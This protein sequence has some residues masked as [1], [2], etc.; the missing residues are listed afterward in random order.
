[1]ADKKLKISLELDDKIF[2]AGVKRA[3]DQLAQLSKSPQIMQMQTQLNQRLSSMGYGGLPGSPDYEKTQQARRKSETEQKRYVEDLLKTQEKL[4]KNEEKLFRLKQ[5]GKNVDKDMADLSA[6]KLKNEGMLTAATEKRVRTY[7][8]LLSNME[9]EYKMGGVAGVKEAWRGMGGAEKA[10][11]AATTA[12]G[13]I[14]LIARTVQYMARRPIEIAA[15][16]GSAVSGLTGLQ[17]SQARTGEY[18]YEGMFGNDRNKATAAAGKAKGMGEIADWGKLIAGA[19]IAGGALLAIPTGGLSLGGAAAIAG[20]IGLA[21]SSHG[22]WDSQKYKAYQA[23]QYTQ[24]FTTV[25]QSEHE[26]Q[27][28][29]KAAIDRLKDTAGRDIGMQRALGLGDQGYYGGG[30]YLQG[31]M[32]LGFT[33]QM[34]TQ[35]SQGILGAGGSSAMARQSGTAL[36]AE[37]GLNLTNAPQLLGMLSGTQ[38]IPEN[39][40]KSLISIFAQGFDSSKYAEENRKFMQGVTQEIFKG[41]TTSVDSAEKI[42]ALM[43]STIT[44]TPTTRNIEAGQSA[45]QA[46][47][48]A[49]SSTTGY[50]GGINVASAMGDK[51]FR[52][53]KDPAELEGLISTPYSQIDENDPGLIDSAKRMGISPK[54]LAD[55]LRNRQISN[56]KTS[57]NRP[58]NSSIVAKRRMIGTVTGLQGV[59]EQQALLNLLEQ[60][61][62]PQRNSEIQKRMTEAEGKMEGKQTGRAGDTMIQASALNARNSLETLSSSINKFAEDAMSAAKMLRGDLPGLKRAESNTVAAQSEYDAARKHPQPVWNPKTHTMDFPAETARRN[63]VNAQD[64]ATAAQ[65]SAGVK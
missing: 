21:S 35:A 54:A 39:S 51:D 44:G 30:G 62:S 6:A 59:P 1:M 13:A 38:S 10:G 5:Q 3:M 15:M 37:R 29:R 60:P 46:F 27:P 45:F 49:G 26:T 57:M 41:G 36:Q 58:G 43:R 63:L 17:L 12:G 23:Q 2:A 61:E 64:Q 42:A 7:R 16:Q 9:K 25:L 31:Q 56:L 24:D 65:Q 4:A 52:K 14:G 34:V 19:A 22:V 8:E 40:K 48:G 33:D 55:K 11:F 50:L 20:G 18:T 32:G 47:Q 53:I 28:L